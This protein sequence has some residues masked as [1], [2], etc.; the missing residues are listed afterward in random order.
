[1]SGRNERMEI[2]KIEDFEGEG[3][4]G[5][6]GRHGLRWVATLSDGSRVGL[7]CA[8]KALSVEPQPTNHSRIADYEIAAECDEWGAHHVMWL[9]A[10]WRQAQ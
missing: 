6:C 7:E 9:V 10:T 8:K 3:E 5:H 2:E 4:C 1:M